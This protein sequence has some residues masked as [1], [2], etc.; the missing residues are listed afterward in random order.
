MRTIFVGSTRL[1]RRCLDSILAIQ[2]IQMV[3]VITNEPTFTISYAP[4]GLKNVLYVDMA[5]Y[6]KERGIPW[7]MMRKTMT[8]PGLMAELKVWRPEL[9]IVAGWY[10][11]LPPSLLDSL[12]AVGLHAS[13]LPDYSG[14]SPLVWA[15]INGEQKT[16]MTLFRLADRVDAGPIIDQASID[17]LPA[18]T[19]ATLYERIELLGIKLLKENLS[20]IAKGTVVYTPQDENRRR[21]LPQRKPEDGRIEWNW[22]SQKIYDFIRAQTHPYPGAFTTFNKQK[23][24]IWAAQLESADSWEERAVG[25]VYGTPAGTIRVNCGMKTTLDLIWVGLEGKDIL[26]EDWFFKFVKQDNAQFV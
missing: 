16:G 13:L 10:H 3:G 12:I 1:S 6:A 5:A 18:D 14:G 17:I 9:L 22:S 20:H 11:I 15:M 25:S 7:Y 26:A 4:Q 21:I 8:E 24:H 2:D 23:V 19:I